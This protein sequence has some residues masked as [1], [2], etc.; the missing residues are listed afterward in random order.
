[1]LFPSLCGYDYSP[2]SPSFLLKNYFFHFNFNVSI[3]FNRVTLVHNTVQASSIQLNEMSSAHCMVCP[4]PQAKSLSVCRPH[5][6]TCSCTTNLLTM[7]SLSNSV[8]KYFFLVTYLQ[9]HFFPHMYQVSWRSQQRYYSFILQCLCFSY[10]FFFLFPSL[11]SLFISPMLFIFSIRVL[12]ILISHFK[13][14]I[15]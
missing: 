11:L 10:F 9:T 2:P 7:N 14:S 13:F 4:S 5:P 6:L 3:E 15:C 1:M 12:N 8:E